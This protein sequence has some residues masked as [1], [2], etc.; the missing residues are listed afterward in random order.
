MIRSILQAVYVFH[1]NDASPVHGVS[2]H[3]VH[4]AI[5]LVSQ[6]QL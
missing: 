6:A 1:P 3:I 5:G 4:V 2:S